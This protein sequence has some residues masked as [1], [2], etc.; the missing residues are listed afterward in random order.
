MR[1]ADDAQPEELTLKVCALVPKMGPMVGQAPLTIVVNDRIVTSQLRIVG[2]DLPQRLTF[3]VPA[4]WLTAGTSPNRAAAPKP[5]G[6]AD[7]TMVRFI[8]TI[9]TTCSSELACRCSHLVCGA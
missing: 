9:A 7:T 1:L 2:G 4:D 8:S 3:S 6:C 5:G